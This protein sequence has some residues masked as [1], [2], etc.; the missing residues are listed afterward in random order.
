MIDQALETSARDVVDLICEE[1]KDPR[2]CY[3]GEL[4]GGDERWYISHPL[5]LKQYQHHRSETDSWGTFL[6][7][8]PDVS[9]SAYRDHTC[10]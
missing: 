6:H 8:F 5:T 9:F 10:L 1:K 7:N 4:T 3:P 2:N